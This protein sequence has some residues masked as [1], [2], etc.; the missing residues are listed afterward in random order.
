[1]VFGNGKNMTFEQAQLYIKMFILQHYDKN[2][3]D[4]IPNA[5]SDVKISSLSCRFNGNWEV[6]GENGVVF[7]ADKNEIK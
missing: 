3:K 6:C 1:M 7:W 5:R 4:V 2:L